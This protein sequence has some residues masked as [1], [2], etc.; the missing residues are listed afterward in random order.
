ML[1]LFTEALGVYLLSRMPGAPDT[2]TVSYALP[3]AMPGKDAVNL[4]LCSL[5]EDAELRENE[6]QYERVGAEWIAV[7]PPLR[8]KCTY[9]V[10]AWP[11]GEDKEEAALVQSGLLSAAYALLV[12]SGTLPSAFIP[13]PMK[14][15]GLPKPIIALT[16]NTLAGSPEFWTSFGCAFRPAFTFSATIS[17]PSAVQDYGYIVEGLDVGYKFGS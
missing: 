13:E 17:I 7:P 16:D 3:G 2:L 12:S 15:P 5:A 9:I 10:S 11:A 8:L 4:F 6:K 1:R 14:A